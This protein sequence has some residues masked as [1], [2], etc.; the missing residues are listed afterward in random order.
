MRSDQ[1]NTK[2][3]KQKNMSKV[4][5]PTFGW[6]NQPTNQPHTTP[7]RGQGHWIPPKVFGSSHLHLQT[8]GLS[9]SALDLELCCVHQ[10]QLPSLGPSSDGGSEGNRVSLDETYRDKKFFLCLFIDAHRYWNANATNMIHKTYANISTC[11]GSRAKDE[12][13]NKFQTYLLR[14]PIRFPMV[15]SVLEIIQ[16]TNA[17]SGSYWNV[18]PGT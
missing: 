9:S 17:R 8:L 13:W 1:K 15:K 18:H 7:L 11:G 5:R 16:R 14:I 10:L 6:T 2:T 12:G 4:W 3:P